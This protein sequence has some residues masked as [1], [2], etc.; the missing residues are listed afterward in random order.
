M[1]IQA[2]EIEPLDKIAEEELKDLKSAGEYTESP[3]AEVS[4]G[5]G[6]ELS[7]E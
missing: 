4:G 5:T 7:L 3:L 1:Y 2:I 6:G